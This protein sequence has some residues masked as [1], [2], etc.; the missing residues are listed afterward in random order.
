MRTHSKHRVGILIF[1]GTKMLDVSGPAEVFAEA[2]L[3]GA[4]YEIVLLST[5][6]RPVITSIGISLPVSGSAFDE[7]E[8]DTVLI[9]GGDVLVGRPIDDALSRAALHLAKDVRI[10][11]I[12]TG[13]FI[14]ASAG[15]LEGRRA[16]T[17]WRH[18]KELAAG[19]PGITVQPDSIFVKDGSIYTSAGVS[20]GIDLALALVEEDYGSDLA[21]KVARSLVVY[22]QRAGG[23]SQ[24]SAS[25][26]GPAPRSSALR[27]IVDAVKAD[28]AGEYPV[29][30]LAQRARMSS[31]QLTRLFREELSTT[32]AKYIE[33]I[34]FDEAKALLDAGYSPTTAAQRSGFG[35]SETLR[36]VFVNRIGI[37]PRRYQ[38][39][40]AT[41]TEND[42]K[43]GG[44]APAGGATGQATPTYEP[45]TD[46]RRS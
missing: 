22:M 31:R 46:A 9:S 18:T 4:D 28:P 42:R 35:N 17:H 7:H 24:Y 11:S 13:A 3:M 12:C 20:A 10:A 26:A 37:A 38:Q 8:F 39:R 1:D 33:T 44:D 25:L 16:T 32:P 45:T 19:H 14:L 40:F 23:Q 21:R 5:D 27:E 2:T 6:G 43:G 30:E 34:R 29:P 15:L 41:T 36:R